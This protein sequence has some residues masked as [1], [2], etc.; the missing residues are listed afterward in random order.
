MSSGPSAEAASILFF[1][2]VTQ[3]SVTWLRCDLLS[4]L[5]LMDRL[6]FAVTQ[7]ARENNLLC[8]PLDRGK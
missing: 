8:E 6:I 2:G 7:N 1:K 4:S 3:S 5:L